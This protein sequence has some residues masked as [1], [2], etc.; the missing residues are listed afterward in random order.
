MRYVIMLEWS[1]QI[2]VYTD[3]LCLN[4]YVSICNQTKWHRKIT[5]KFADVLAM[6]YYDN[7]VFHGR[8]SLY[9]IY[10]YILS[11]WLRPC[12]TTDKTISE[13]WAT[14]WQATLQ[15]LLPVFSCRI[16]IFIFRDISIGSVEMKLYIITE[17]RDY[18]CLSNITVQN[19]L[20][21]S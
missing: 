16:L 21:K 15:K 10:I 5:Q 8:E 7:G 20:Y 19:S 11:Q 9:R 4:P 13:S 6:A 14:Q 3:F 17:S 1:A 18:V 2:F 12:S